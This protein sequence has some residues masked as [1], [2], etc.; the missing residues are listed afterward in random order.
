MLAMLSLLLP[1][2]VF[3]Q[4]TTQM[5]G[6]IY[7]PSSKSSPNFK[8]EKTTIETPDGGHRSHIR[9]SDLDGK[10]L[11][12]EEFVYQGETP[13]L[14]RY[15]QKQVHESGEIKI[16]QNKVFYS[17]SK[18]GKTETDSDSLEP[19]TVF[20]DMI[21]TLLQ[22]NWALLQNGDSVK[23]RLLLVER[24]ETVGFKF[25][26]DKERDYKGIPAVDFTMKP[27]SFII[28]ALAPS[29]TIT[30]SKASPHRLLETNGRLPVRVAEV[31]DPKRRQ[32]W[33]AIDAK[34]ILSYPQETP[35]PSAGK[36]SK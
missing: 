21:P 11:V 33:R 35:S 12:E 6:D 30:V 36:D 34:M 32:D 19:E 24:L 27:S 28:A 13:I 25:F 17:Y 18:Q 9:Y 31:P 1:V 15:D 16:E 5:L 2:A 7:Y 4:S 26:K 29:I 23:V 14:Y 22:K 10:I 8:Y 3:A 20:T